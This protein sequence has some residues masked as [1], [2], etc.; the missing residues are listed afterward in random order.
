MH[1]EVKKALAFGCMSAPAKRSRSASSWPQTKRGRYWL[2]P[3]SP[4]AA[5]FKG[6]IFHWV[7]IHFLPLSC[8]DVRIPRPSNTWERIHRVGAGPQDQVNFEI[9]KK[10]QPSLHGI[11]RRQNITQFRITISNP[12]NMNVNP[13]PFQKLDIKQ[14]NWSGMI[15]PLN[16]QNIYHLENATAGE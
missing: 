2:Y 14:Q 16:C 15:D 1:D 12:W 7:K 10:D 3:F 4:V 6:C 13:F 8:E 5:P 9:Q 11:K